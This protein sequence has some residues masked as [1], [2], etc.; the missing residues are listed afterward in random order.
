MTRPITVR[1]LVTVALAVSSLGLSG[2]AAAQVLPSGLPP[3]GLP[4][5][6]V[7]PGRALGVVDQTVP[8]LERRAAQALVAPASLRD[9]VGR[10]RGALV[11]D[12]QGYPAVAG[13]IV[14][15]DPTPQSLARA[16]ADGFV[17]LRRE[18]LE[19]LDLETVVLAPPRREPLARA[20]DRLRR[21]APEAE[22]AFNHVHAPSGLSI[23]TVDAGL[24]TAAAG[25]RQNRAAALGLI[26]TGV[27]ARHPAFVGMDIVQRGFSGA[28]R[29]AD[30][31]TAVASLMVG[32]AGAF[33][34]AAPGAGLRVADVYGGSAAGGSST[35]LARALAWLVGDGARVINVSL[36][37]PRNALVERAV[38]QARARGVQIVAAVGNDGPA[39]PPLYPA[40]YAGVI[41]VAPV[42]RRDRILP[43]AGRGHHVDF[44]APGSDMAAAAVNGRWVVVRGASFAAPLVAGLLARGGS[45]EALSRQALDLGAPGFDPVCGGGLIGADLRVAPAAVGARGRLSR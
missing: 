27:D 23:E 24:A 36:V 34:G 17:I 31:G 3:I 5:L 15:L 9:L 22:V 1:L 8:A 26:D 37:G 30:H 42:D 28:T 12:P 41:A 10:S 19:D 44:V 40:A 13:E 33:Q 18:R 32:R 35:A 21:L 38:A 20:V 7:E 39:A 6:P 2:A 16:E 29:P 11:A 25:Q 45:P 14:M 43:E 4:T